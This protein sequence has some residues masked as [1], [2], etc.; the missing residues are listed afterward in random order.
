MF[1]MNKNALKPKCLF[2]Q[3]FQNDFAQRFHGQTSVANHISSES[4]CSS[5][6]DFLWSP[7]SNTGS[8]LHPKLG[9]AR[10]SHY[11]ITIVEPRHGELTIPN[12][13]LTRIL[14]RLLGQGNRTW[15]GKRL[16]ALL[17]HLSP[18]FLLALQ[19][20]DDSS[21]QQ[22]VYIRVAC[23][24]SLQGKWCGNCLK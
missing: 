10:F 21:T 1:G 16:C 12:A 22:L 4:S 6:V 13:R 19:I 11:S 2:S 23:C 5:R 14:N 24:C 18:K 15:L 17:S 8:M 9:R 20:L 7:A 3:N